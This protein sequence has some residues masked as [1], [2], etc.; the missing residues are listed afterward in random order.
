LPHEFVFVPDVGPVLAD[1][2]ER[3]ESF[4]QAWNFG[5]PETITGREFI[6]QVYRAAGREPRFRTV[7][8]LVLRVGGLFNPLLRELVELYYLAETPVVL[9]DSKLLRY[10]GTVH[11]TTYSEGIPIAMDWYRSQNRV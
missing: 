10:S 7:G 8:P 1:L 11:K 6:A 5:G 3:E 2:I 4:G 9:D